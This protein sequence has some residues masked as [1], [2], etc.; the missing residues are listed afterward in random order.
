MAPD[1]TRRQDVGVPKRRD[2]IR[3]TDEEV[4][5][6]L[7]GRHTM[8]IATFGPDGKIHLVA[9]WYGFTADGNPAFETFAKSQK[10]LNA[11]RDDR[12][13]VLVEDGEEYAELRGVEIVGRAVIHRDEGVLFEV[14]KSVARR[15]FGVETEEDAEAVA[16]GLMQKRVAVEIVPEKVVSW[17]H[18]K[19]EGKY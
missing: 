13:T 2:L 18:T 1:L 9:M 11:E 8:N 15:Y 4:D 14:A 17:D 10:V 6:F 7:Q 12:I 16:V 5:D 3:M 19:L